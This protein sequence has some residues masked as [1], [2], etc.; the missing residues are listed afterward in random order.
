M[1]ARTSSLTFAIVVS[2][3][4]SAFNFM[5][6]DLKTS[7]EKLVIAERIAAI[8]ARKSSERARAR[9]KAARRAAS[10]G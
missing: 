3:L 1:I 4:A 5:M 6:E 2:S 10:T 9:E 8:R 7:K